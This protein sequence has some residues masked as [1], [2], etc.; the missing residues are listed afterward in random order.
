MKLAG[1]RKTGACTFVAMVL[2][3]PFVAGLSGV[4]K[5]SSAQR[6]AG[7]LRF[8]GVGKFPGARPWTSV[9]KNI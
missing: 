9:L 1:L 4:L 7:P 5:R 3:L 6:F 8:Y 2:C